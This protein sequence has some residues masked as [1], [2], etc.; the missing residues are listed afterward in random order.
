MEAKQKNYELL[1]R[2]EEDVEHHLALRHAIMVA[3]HHV[4]SGDYRRDERLAG[5]GFCHEESHAVAQQDFL[6]KGHKKV[7]FWVNL[8]II[9]I[10][11]ITSFTSS[12]AQN[13]A[14]IQKIGILV[15]MEK[16]LRMLENY[17]TD[18]IIIIEKCGIGKVNAAIGCAEMI[19]KYNPDFI[20]SMGCAGGHGEDVHIG[21]VVV[22]S[23]TVYHD[24]YCGSEVKYGQVFGL[25]S[26]FMS[27]PTLLNIAL[28]IDENIVPG[29]ISTGD[30]FVDS[31]EKIQ[32]II[33]HFPETKAI[34]MESAAIAQVCHI[35]Q[36]PFISFRII[37]DKPLEDEH[38][39]QYYDF[40]NKTSEKTFR[41]A[42]KYTESI[43]KYYKKE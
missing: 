9:L 23:E 27:D 41:I 17:F 43:I 22:S 15:A 30:W 6:P 32:D 37:S 12:H 10:I 11:M 19:Y 36:I 33:T 7:R 18:S 31:K 21:N 42:K 14:N 40:W 25:P 24:V 35:H 38:A 29:L 13:Y 1:L 16:E 28:N 26:R 39:S 3:W 2:Q 20:I 8:I 5:A 34:D 4:V